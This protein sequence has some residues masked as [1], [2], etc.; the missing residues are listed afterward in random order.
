MSSN[1]WNPSSLYSRRGF[2]WLYARKYTASRSASRFSRW[3]CHLESMLRRYSN[4]MKRFRT[5]S[6]ISADFSLMLSRSSSRSLLHLFRRKGGELRRGAERIVVEALLHLRKEG[7]HAR[8]RI[9][10]GAAEALVDLVEQLLPRCN[11][12]V[13]QVGVGD[14]FIAPRVDELA[15]L[16][17][18]I[19]V[20]Q[21]VLADLEVAF[22]HLFL[23]PL[24]G[25]VQP[26]MDNGLA[27]LHAHP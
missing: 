16:V 3:S 2:F 17:E 25:A 6:P 19:V 21:E 20:F 24:D 11:D 15:L 1:I 10:T 4:W 18:N 8:L 13:L 22:L 12:P 7:R 26:R 5:S 23:R 27:L 9:V 14:D